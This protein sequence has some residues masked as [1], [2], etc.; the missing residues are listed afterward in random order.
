MYLEMFHKWET[1]D[2]KLEKLP[3][4][5]KLFGTISSLKHSCLQQHT[6]PKTPWWDGIFT[7]KFTPHGQL[8]LQK[9]FQRHLGI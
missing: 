6:I 7:Y 1:L 8:I 9:Q 3:R 5:I 2:I 4:D